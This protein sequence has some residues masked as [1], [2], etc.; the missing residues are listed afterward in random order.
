MKYFAH[1]TNDDTAY[2][3]VHLNADQVK[4]LREWMHTEDG[5]NVGFPHGVYL[6]KRGFGWYRLDVTRSHRA[7]EK[8]RHALVI[9]K[10]WHK[11][12]VSDMDQEI[13]LLM[14]QVNPNLQ[15][16]SYQS[17]THQYQVKNVQSGKREHLN[18]PPSPSKLQALASKFAR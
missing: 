7:M 18:L 13:K 15:I 17:D 6:F 5:Q 10:A 16:A 2:I 9:M 14:A 3:T 12:Y 11:K 1:L 8:L 4:H